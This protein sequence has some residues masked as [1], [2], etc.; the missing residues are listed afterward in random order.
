MISSADAVR[1]QAAGSPELSSAIRVMVAGAGMTKFF[2]KSRRP[3]RRSFFL[4]LDT[5]DFAWFLSGK[6]GKNSTPEGIGMAR[7]G[8]IIECSDSRDWRECCLIILFLY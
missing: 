3:E 2:S 7:G 6:A 4:R 5:F 8:L 1:H